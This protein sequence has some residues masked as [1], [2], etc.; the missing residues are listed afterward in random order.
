M[1]K[2]ENRLEM[3]DKSLVMAFSVTN[4]Y[5]QGKNKDETILYLTELLF[6]TEFETKDI[7]DSIDL[8]L[9]KSKNSPTLSDL[10]EILEGPTN[11]K[12]TQEIETK[13]Q[14]FLD[15]AF[16]THN[17]LEDWAYDIKKTMG[18]SRIEN[19]YAKDLDS[20]F[21]K[22]FVE[23]VT[24]Q[25]NG[26]IEV[27]GDSRKWTQI[28]GA[29]C[30]ES[31]KKKDKGMKMI[32]KVLENKEE[33]DEVNKFNIKRYLD[34]MSEEASMTLKE[35]VLAMVKKDLFNPDMDRN[36]AFY[37]SMIQAKLN[38]IVSE[39]IRDQ[40]SIKPKLKVAV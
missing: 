32:G 30:L 7:L 3:I 26:E 21:K 36:T 33:Y 20:W 14:Y 16:S 29:L 24:R 2:N 1:I 22:D 18:S 15:F 11:N 5:S 10:I 34:S 40:E 31:T 8:F 12:I 17:K 38:Q 13:W 4:F 25:I 37:K 39:R 19:F 9:R 23:H 6:K 28:G 35:D 27:I